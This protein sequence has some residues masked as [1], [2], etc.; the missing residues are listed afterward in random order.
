[1]GRGREQ[2][3]KRLVVECAMLDA[4]RAGADVDVVPGPSNQARPLVQG[5]TRDGFAASGRGRQC[6]VTIITSPLHRGYCC[7]HNLLREIFL[8]PITE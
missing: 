3:G 5:C 6:G 2:V 7:M 8:S 1:M 4:S